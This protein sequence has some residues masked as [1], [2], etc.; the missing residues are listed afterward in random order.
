MYAL[1]MDETNKALKET[2]LG[3]KVPHTDLKIPCLLWMDDVVLAETSPASSQK[4]LD[5]TNETSL[6]YHVQ[7]GMAKTKYLRTGK[8]KEQITLK[9]GNQIV[10]ETDKYT[11]LGEVNNKKMN[12]EDQIKSIEGKVEAAYQTIIA[13]AEDREFKKIKMHTIWTLIQTCIIPLITY[14]SETWQ[15]SKQETKRL[16]QILDKILRRILMTPDATPREALYVET[17]LLD[18]R[19]IA[20]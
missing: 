4:Q 6:K 16:N 1:M 5:I 17:G 20:D 18:V 2:E 3:V 11:Y 19:T 15:P 9:L 14:A 7:Y 10:D 8:N 12:L 13:I